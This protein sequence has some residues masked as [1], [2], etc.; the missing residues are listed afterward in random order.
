MGLTAFVVFVVPWMVL[1]AWLFTLPSAIRLG[2]P[3]TPWR[4]L[5]RFPDTSRDQH[6]NRQQ[7]VNSYKR[8]AHVGSGLT[9]GDK[10]EPVSKPTAGVLGT[11]VEAT[12]PDDK[13]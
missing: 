13:I 7:E 2:A 10:H 6:P 5:Y 4:Q 3:S 1:A 9:G 8:G 11:S 12:E